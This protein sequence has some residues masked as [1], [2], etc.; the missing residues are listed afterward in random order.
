MKSFLNEMRSDWNKEFND[1][2]RNFNKQLTKQLNEIENKHEIK[3][4]NYKKNNEVR[5][6]EKNI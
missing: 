6:N 4:K 1:I 5:K 3:N 2:R